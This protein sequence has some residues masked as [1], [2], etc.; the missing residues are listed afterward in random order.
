MLKRMTSW[1]NKTAKKQYLKSLID[2]DNVTATQYNMSRPH[3]L[4]Q[5]IQHP[6]FGHGFI[7][8]ILGENKIQVF[9]EAAEE[10]VLLQNWI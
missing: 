1:K 7:Q 6:K 5:F 4:G 8:G 9:F 2:A 3:R 10:R